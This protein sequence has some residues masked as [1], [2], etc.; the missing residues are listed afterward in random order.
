[1]ETMM[2]GLI[3][4]FVLFALSMLGSG[5]A[6]GQVLVIANPGV[7]ADS[8]SRAELRGVFTGS[9]TRLKDGS[10]VKPVLLKE[11]PT[12]AA[13]VSSDLSLSEAGLLVCW[14]GLVFSGQS[15]MPHSFESEAAE[16]EFIA[17]TPGAIGY[18]SVSTPHAAV[19]VLQ[20][21]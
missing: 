3:R 8:I 15:V 18:I 2:K 1:M 20:V 19:K 9:A 6:G 11:G 21:K 17:A 12:H 16:V 7:N 14:R 4:V 13:F 10:H 5:I